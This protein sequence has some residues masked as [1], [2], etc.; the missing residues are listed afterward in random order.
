[1]F[2]GNFFFSVNPTY[3]EYYCVVLRSICM[4]AYVAMHVQ[5]CMH[6][7]IVYMYADLECPYIPAL[8]SISKGL[9][10]DHS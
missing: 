7:C 8:V 6:A 5:L 4:H 10:D 1:M 3:T 9:L 2:Y